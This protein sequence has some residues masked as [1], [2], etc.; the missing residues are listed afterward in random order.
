MRVLVMGGTR[1]NGLHL[2]QELVKHGHEVTTFN[3]G[4]TQA[5]LPP[6][7]RRLHGDRTD[8]EAMREVFADEE[9]DCI[10]DMSAYTTD[11]VR[12]MDEIFHGRT[13]HYIFASSTA[14]YAHAKILPIRETHP[15]DLSEKQIEYGRNKIACEQYLTRA[16]RDHGFPASMVPFASVFGPH[17]MIRDR[18]Q[19][20]F[21]RLLQGR[22]ALVPGDGTTL[23]QIGHVDDEA[24]ALRM[25]MLNPNTFGKRYNLTGKDYFTDEGYIDT[26]ADVIGVT[27]EKISVPAALM[28]DLWADK[29]PLGGGP[30]VD[31]RGAGGGAWLTRVSQLVQRSAPNIHPWNQNVIFSIDRLMKEINWE[32]E[33]NFR[34][35]VEQ[36]FEWFMSE[37][38]DKTLAE[39]LDFSLEELLLERI[40]SG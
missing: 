13:G 12:S 6:G 27:P 38:L 26:I 2:V 14:I 11:D 21:V 28:N 33:Y 37:G 34:S 39:E 15:V 7:V 24:K 9:F 10:Q 23:G 36:T 29:L 40:R 19:R 31:R 17:N 32:P 8:H 30:L 35:A 1:F 22:P 3:R 4:I 18:E 25:M 5:V 16:Y 20:M